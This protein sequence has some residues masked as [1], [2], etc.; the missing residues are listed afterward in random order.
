MAGAKRWRRRAL[1][2]GVG[3]LA[4]LGAVDLFGGPF[5]PLRRMRAKMGLT[6]RNA[7]LAVGQPVPTTP[8][9]HDQL[10]AHDGMQRQYILRIPQGYD[11]S[12][13]IP[14][15]LVLR[16]GNQNADEY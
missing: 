1:I 9:R 13:A 14:L 5:N 16:G 2:G 8:G 6:A 11:G 15:M 12:E 10:I 7:G 3:T 4:F